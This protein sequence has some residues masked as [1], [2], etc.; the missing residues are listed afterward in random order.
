MTAMVSGS[1]QAAET[2][3]TDS[4][5]NIDVDSSEKVIGCSAPRTVMP[6]PTAH[7]TSRIARCEAM[8][9]ARSPQNSA[10]Q[11]QN[12]V[13]FTQF[14]KDLADNALPNYSFVTPNLCNDA[15][16]CGMDVADSWLQAHIAP[17]VNNA[18]F[19]KD[20]LLIITFDESGSDNT[21]GGGLIPFIVVTPQGKGHF[22]STT[23]YQH[24]SLL[25][26]TL[27]ALGIK[28]WPGAAATAP[29]MS[30]FFTVPLP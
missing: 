29:S 26:L 3:I 14:S 25:R 5:V 7:I 8:S 24:Q 21:N 27:Q 2:A 12:L 13:P 18:A 17:L 23:F 4:P 10:T 22:Q 28:T 6:A 20:G 30:E 9:P 1:V 19:Q 11:R 16:D 15:H